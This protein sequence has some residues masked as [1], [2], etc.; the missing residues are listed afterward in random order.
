MTN[1]KKLQPEP[2]VLPDSPE[3]LVSLPQAATMLDCSVDTIR[4]WGRDGKLRIV[5]LPGGWRVAK[6]SIDA[7][8]INASTMKREE[9]S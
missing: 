2:V 6:A 7:L 1:R 4:R 8:F 5:R 3:E 9:N